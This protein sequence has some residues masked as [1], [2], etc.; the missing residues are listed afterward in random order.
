ME[1]NVEFGEATVLRGAVAAVEATYGKASGLQVPATAEAHVHR[2]RQEDAHLRVQVAD[3][4]TT[5]KQYPDVVRRARRCPGDGLP[6]AGR[7]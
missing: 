5:A 3:A 6:V 4:A 7:C 1:S 2:R